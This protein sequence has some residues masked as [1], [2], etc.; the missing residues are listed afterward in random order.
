V[1]E[2][3]EAIDR[4][5][6]RRVFGSDP[7]TYDRARPGHA[8]RAYEILVE[9]C[10]LGRGTSV[11]EVG[12]GTGQ[13]TRRLLELGAD[14]LVA[15]EPNED[16]A[17]Y[18]G[19]AVGERVDIRVTP[20]EDA[21][22]RESSFD[23]AA[24]ASSFHWI[25]EETGLATVRRAL[26]PGGWIALWWTGFGDPTRP[27][28]FRDATT[29]LLSAMPKSPVGSHRGGRTPTEEGSAR[30]LSSL[31]AAG[32]EDVSHERISWSKT[33]DAKGIREIFSTFSPFLVVDEERRTKTLDE[34]ERIARD[35]FDDRIE[36]PIVTAL[37]TA[38]KPA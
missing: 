35:E 4:R 31:D 2:Q 29:E 27:D 6:G 18:L 5:E 37:Y 14:P 25:D 9:R 10:G 36:K 7:E 21:V 15:I 38:R 13:A 28:P 1:S 16:L 22:L 34:L 23:L 30:W 12:P 8:E 19:R 11:L 26:R 3:R 20:L 17:R 32:F 33:F 24:A